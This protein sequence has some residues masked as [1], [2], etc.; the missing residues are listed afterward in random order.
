MELSRSLIH[1]NNLKGRIVTQ[2]TLDDD[3]NV[4]DVNADIDKYITRDALVHIEN[5]KGSEGRVNVRGHMDFKILYGSSTDKRKIHSM[6]NV[7]TAFTLIFLVFIM[8]MFKSSILH[9]L[10]LFTLSFCAIFSHI[11]LLREYC[12]ST[13]L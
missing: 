2:V 9:F 8:P 6:E 3:F 12:P 11:C 7:S 1:M 5:V 13:S 4:P 10:K